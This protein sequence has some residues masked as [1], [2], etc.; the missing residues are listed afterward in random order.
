MWSGPAYTYIRLFWL[1]VKMSP[2]ALSC[3]FYFSLEN[4]NRSLPYTATLSI[5]LILYSPHV[6]RLSDDKLLVIWRVSFDIKIS[7][8]VCSSKTPKHHMIVLN[9]KE[10]LLVGTELIPRQRMFEIGEVKIEMDSF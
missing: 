9:K 2:V 4:L 1:L 10:V 3:V 8:T 7:Q 5:L 6:F